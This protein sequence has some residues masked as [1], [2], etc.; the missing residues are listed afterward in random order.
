MLEEYGR[1]TIRTEYG[2]ISY[3]IMGKECLIGDIFVDPSLR[4]KGLGQKLGEMV[5][6]AARE[7]GATYLSCFVTV[8]ERED[9][10]TR[11]VRIF[12][13]FGFKIFKVVGS[14]I[15]MIK[16]LGHAV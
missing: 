12:M 13:D 11:K 16:E 3:K 1:K 15:I 2:F 10:V 4:H 5:E 8:D 6:A 7:A 9:F 14:Q